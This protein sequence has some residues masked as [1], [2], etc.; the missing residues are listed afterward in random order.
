MKKIILLI[1]SVSLTL[2]GCSFEDF[3]EISN[4]RKLINFK[5][6]ENKEN[7]E[8]TENTVKSLNGFLQYELPLG[9]EKLVNDTLRTEI[10]IEKEKDGLMVEYLEYVNYTS[11]KF[12]EYQE[13]MTEV[14]E[15]GF[16]L[17]EEDAFEKYG[18]KMI[19]KI[20]ELEDT[21]YLVGT[22]EFDEN[23][24]NF[25]GFSSVIT[26]NKEI[27]KEIFNI[28][29]SIQFT[30]IKLNEEK[31]A[32]L[33]DGKIEITLPPGWVKF[34]NV[35][36]NDFLK[37]ILKD[38]GM[39]LLANDN[40]IEIFTE[41]ETGMEEKLEELSFDI[42]SSLIEDFGYVNEEELKTEDLED[43][44]IFSKLYKVDSVGL[45]VYLNVIDFKDSDLLITSI[46]K[47]VKQDSP[48]KIK[49]EFEASKEELDK[50]VK[51]IK[52]IQN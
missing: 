25:L 52:I 27:T 41:K 21:L 16:D 28:L 37:K 48:E 51:S 23:K 17:K 9:W 1:L 20:Y 19:Y 46:Y 32:V 49:E 47:I 11:E 26:N 5:N 44:T 50:M 14:K 22:L 33:G 35:T 29:L 6:K 18:K 3:S 30:D 2:T 39:F 24:E 38:D 43:R 34:G 42:T 12:I 13:T 8:N 7:T 15:L 31:K 45:Y 36:E 10:A 40:D 4:I